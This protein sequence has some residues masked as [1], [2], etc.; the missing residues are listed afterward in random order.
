MIENPYFSNDE[1]KC[2]CCGENKFNDNTLRRLI[3]VREQVGPM[4]ISSGFRCE[5]YNT[6]KGYTQTHAT[7]QAVDVRIAGGDAL[8]VVGMAIRAGFTG[9]GVSQKGDWAGRFIHLDDL[10]ADQAPRPA[11]WSY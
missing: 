1:L 8:R 9:V 10:T 7:G 6:A 3:A 11:M 2:S 4:V 5:A